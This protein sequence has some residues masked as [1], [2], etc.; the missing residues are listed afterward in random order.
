MDFLRAFGG[1]DVPAAANRAGHAAGV[2]HVGLSDC[3]GAVRGERA[4][5]HGQHLAGT[6]GAFVHRAAPD[7]VGI[8]FLPSL[9]GEGRPGL[10]TCLIQTQAKELPPDGSSRR[11]AELL[12]QGSAPWHE[13]G[14]EHTSELQSPCN[15]VCRLLLEK[16][17][18][19]TAQS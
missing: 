19:R 9:A 4:R 14:E 3:A 2:P 1:G 16:K 8:V 17:K 10:E 6:P 15:L 5:A 12:R 13:W 18:K 7:F 11:F